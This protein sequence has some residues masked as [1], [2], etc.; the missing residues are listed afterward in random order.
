MQTEAQTFFKDLLMLIVCSLIML[1]ILK[2]P[3]ILDYGALSFYLALFTTVLA[4]VM[5]MYPLIMDARF[6]GESFTLLNLE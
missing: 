2:C 6:L 1:N 4:F 3:E 5:Y